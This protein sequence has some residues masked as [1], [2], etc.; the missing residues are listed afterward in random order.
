MQTCPDLSVAAAAD[1]SGWLDTVIQLHPTFFPT[2]AS[3]ILTLIAVTA[4]FYGVFKTRQSAREKNSIDFQK[5]HKNN[6][7]VNEAWLYVRRNIRGKPAKSVAGY[8]YVKNGPQFR[9]LATLLNDWE[10]VATGVEHGVYDSRYLYQAHGS[11]FLAL[12]KDALP[13][14]KAAQYEQPRA[15]IALSK[16]A[17]RWLE[18]RKF[19]N[20]HQIQDSMKALHYG[21]HRLF[22]QIEQDERKEK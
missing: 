8:F 10:R 18:F 16:M 19:E 2:S 13:F 5:E 21:I 7:E 12:Y 15:F 3:A 14:I 9:N 1:N 17:Y 6:K 20:K 4:A 22:H 11:N